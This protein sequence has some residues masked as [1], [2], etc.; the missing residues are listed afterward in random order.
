MKGTA[1]AAEIKYYLDYSKWNEQE[2]KAETWPESVKRV[3]DMHRNNPKFQEAFKNPRFNELFNL[4]EQLYTDKV[5][6]GSQRALQFGGAPIMKHNAKMFNC[7]GSY[8]DRAEFFQ[9]A[10]YW[11]MCGC[12]IGY[13]VQTQHVAKLP[14]I[15]HR[16]DGTKTFVVPDSIEGWADAFGVLTSSFFTGEVPHPEYQNFQVYF[17]YSLIRPKGSMI[18]GG[19]KAP[20]PDGL[21]QAIERAEELLNKALREGNKLRPIQCYDLVCHMAD[22]VLSGGVRRSAS[23]C[24]FSKEDNEMM[25]AKDKENY[26]TQAGINKQRARSNNSVVLLRSET[27]QEEFDKIF[28]KIKAWGEPGFYFVDDLDQVTNPCVEIGFYAMLMRL[29]KSGW[30]GCNLTSANG[31]KLNTK[32][33]FLQACIGMA[34]LGTLQA[35]YT[36]FNY[37]SPITKEIFDKE[38]LLGC[39]ITGWMNNPEVLLNEEN[40]KEGS[41]LILS[42]NEEVAKMIGINPCARATCVKPEGNTSVLLETES[43]VHGAHSKRSFRTMQINKE[44]EIGKYLAENTPF[45]IEESVWSA[46]NSDYVVYIPVTAKKGSI[47]KDELIGIKQLEVVRSI[48]QNW[49]EYGTRVE[50]CTKPFLRHN[51]SNTVEVG[52]SNWD[53]VKN[54]V[55]EHRGSFSGVSFLGKFGDK[56]YKQAPFTSVLTPEEILEKYGEASMFA[57]GLVVDALH[58]FDNDLWTACNY[59]LNRQT[60]LEGT[61]REV[62]LMKDWLRRAK[63][64]SKRYFKNNMLNM[65]YCLKDVYLYHKWMEI[66]REYVPIDFSKINLKPNY[67]DVDTM[68]SASCVGGACEMPAGYLERFETVK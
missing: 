18:S 9:E 53:D 30:Q 10:M 42:I 12:G 39:S 62:L 36:D 22:A 32:E 26:N 28:E 15:T 41:Q 52:D 61:K 55:Y 51:V 57:S 43:G 49:V 19:F 6:V 38:A 64:F 20:G 50:S 11:L 14:S 45:M 58:D 37:V 66:N 34:F 59:A 8:C 67:V 4:T 29:M 44:A 5:I 54:Y 3:M 13:S 24:L 48:Q 47:M 40:M 21:K 31:G 35:S 25:S 16:N 60:K 56:D 33:K 46:S 27:T 63:Q 1:L 65:T 7:L 23:I 68:G 17:D 2:N